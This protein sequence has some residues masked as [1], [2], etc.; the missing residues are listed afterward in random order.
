MKYRTT[1]KTTLLLILIAV[2]MMLCSCIPTKE[3]RCA[4]HSSDQQIE[5]TKSSIKQKDLSSNTT[6]PAAIVKSAYYTE[7]H[8]LTPE[9][10]AIWLRNTISVNGRGPM[11]FL[12][13]KI[14]RNVNVHIKY[15]P[16]INKNQQLTISYVGT[17]RG[18]LDEI[19][20][21]TGYAYNATED[22]V[23]WTDFVTKTFDIAFMPGNSTYM[24]GGTATG[25]TT[26]GTSGTSGSSSNSSYSQMQASLSI[27]NDITSTLNQ[28]KSKDGKIFVSQ[29]TTTVTVS[30]HPSNVAEM[31][32][33]IDQ[34]NQDMS[35]QVRLKIQVLEVD[36]NESHSYGIDWNLVSHMLG[37]DFSLTAH[38][39][40]AVSGAVKGTTPIAFRIGDD[41]SNAVLN[42]LS[43]QG[44]VSVVT[45]PTVITL[46]NQAAE[47]RINTDTAYLQSVTTTQVSQTGST[48][49]SLTPGNINEGFTLYL[50]P[51][52]KGNQ[53]FLQI[54]SDLSS[55]VDL[56]AFT[57][58]ANN[59]SQTI[60]LPT[61][62]SKLFNIRSVVRNDNTLIIGGFK[63]TNDQKADTKMLNLDPLGGHAARKVK[64]ET[65]LLITPTILENNT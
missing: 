13:S 34:L 61:I 6:A 64:S 56:Q 28:L 62:A 32:E 43:Q 54:S 25:G 41:K 9:Q 58:G 27:W 31:T 4:I 1:L 55:L 65:I 10:R 2:A 35:Q 33:Y 18:A 45:E 12:V 11:S 51:K 19:A 17:I 26:T 48:Q 5:Q 42:A 40:S 60:Q 7:R 47:V 57:S 24:I 52:I 50:V 15:D 44:K 37:T 30:D 63:Q 46:N 14:L 53:I 22:S 59:G 16:S 20:D 38:L 39:A 36:L 49:T 3:V 23:H 21:K 8:P 29:S